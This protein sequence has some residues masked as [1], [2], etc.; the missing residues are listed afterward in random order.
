MRD[1]NGSMRVS[2]SKLDIS[3]KI[4]RVL[5]RKS[6][7]CKDD[8]QVSQPMNLGKEQVFLESLQNITYP[9]EN[10]SLQENIWSTPFLI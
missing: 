4:Q 1:L 9:K 5:K 7:R 2:S 10:L 8:S 3:Q 6:L